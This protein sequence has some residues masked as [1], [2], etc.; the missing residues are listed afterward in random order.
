[1][2]NTT[3]PKRLETILA[4]ANAASGDQFEATQAPIYLSTTYYRDQHGNYPSGHIYGRD[5]VPSL[6]P[7]ETAMASAEGGAV[8]LAFS[9]GLAA[10]TTLLSA[11][12]PNGRIVAPTVLYYGVDQ[13]LHHFAKRQ[14]LDFVQVDYRDEEA[15]QRVLSGGGSGLMWIECPGNPYLDFP[16]I[17]KLSEMA[18][19][20]GLRVAVDASGAT[21]VLLQP[22]ALGADFVVHSATK[23]LGGH[24]DTLAGIVVGKVRDELWDAL[25]FARR[26]NGNQL[27][28]FEA[29]LLARSLETLHVRMYAISKNVIAVADYLTRNSSVSVVHHPSVE[30]HPDHEVATRTMKGLFPGLLSFELKGNKQD[31]MAF[32]ANL[33]TV[34]SAT[35]FGGVQSSIEH[36]ASVRS[37]YD[38]RIPVSESL[39]RMSVGIE[40]EDDIIQDLDQAFRA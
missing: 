13:W 3:P 27:G 8:A 37:L 25:V 12:P 36:H 21:P 20:A 33:Q 26:E 32:V 28:G 39:L 7:F 34:K 14:S 30:T 24:S 15:L 2:K 38:A 16:D 6:L 4:H 17:R 19:A 9:S 10:I 31:A 22:L 35:S 40:H 1:M 11:L 5:D 23:Y 18:H 29:W